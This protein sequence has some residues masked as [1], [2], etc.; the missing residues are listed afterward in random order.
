MK[1][2][3]LAGGDS[4][5]S[6]KWIRYF[7]DRGHEVH[8]ISFAPFT[9]KKIQNAKLYLIKRNLILN[10][11]QVRAL[12]KEIKPDILH[13]HYAGLNGLLGALSGFHP[14]VLTAWGSDVLLTARSKIKGLFVRYALKEADFITCDAEHM[15]E[16]M[17]KLGVNNSKIKI[18]NFGIDTKKFYPNSKDDILIKNLG[19]SEYKIIMSLRSLEP[20][21]DLE[22]LIKTIPSVLKEFPK[23]YL[24]IA[25]EGS[26]EK[27]LRKLADDLIITKNI[28]F[29]GRITN[30][31][32]PKYLRIADVYV[33]TSLSDGGIAASTAEAMACGLPVVITDVADNKKWVKDGENGFIIPIKNPKIL[34]ER[35]IY[36]LKNENIGKKFGEI[37]RKIIEEKNN[38]YKEMKKMEEIYTGLLKASTF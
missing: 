23:T 6:Y 8:W 14:F 10:I 20:V 32:L 25:G 21:Y 13:A 7:S 22:T 16:A 35:I 38:Y 11:F 18:I 37:S 28:R 30:D 24:I 5:H 29:V 9:Q 1:I 15:K 33:S 27:E 34:A 31:E 3:F 19:V 2:C 4:I 26:Q 12:I 36:L 17:I